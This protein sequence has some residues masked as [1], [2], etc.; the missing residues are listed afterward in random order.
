MASTKVMAVVAIVVIAVVAIAAFVLINNNSGSTSEGSI[1]TALAVY[2]NANNDSTIDKN[3]IA[4][5][6]DIIDNKKSL[7]DYPFADA[8]CDKVVD[9]KDIDVVNSIINKKATSVKIQCLDPSGNATVKDVAY[10]LVNIAVIGTNMVPVVINAGAVPVVA[11][12][13]EG[14]TA[15][16]VLEKE[17][18][19]NAYS[20]GKAGRTA[21][22][23]ELWKNFTDRSAALKSET[24]IGIQASV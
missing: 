7:K 4:I 9:S 22:S 8:N 12:W 6:N 18:K 17:M 15:Y 21:L 11:G 10:P 24:G 20:L 5:I 13:Y 3:D 19:D 16:P 14:S 1:D 2:G 23:D